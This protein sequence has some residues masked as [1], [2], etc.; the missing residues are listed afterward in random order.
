VR[1]ILEEALL[2]PQHITYPLP[3][4]IIGCGFFGVLFAEK[5]VMRWSKRRTQ[6]SCKTAKFK[7]LI[8]ILIK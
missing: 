8:L 1:D 4:F 6:V 5:L 3:D 7:Y 2:A